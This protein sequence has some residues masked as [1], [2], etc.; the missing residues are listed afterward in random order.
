M[1]SNFQVFCLILACTVTAFPQ[2]Q[3]ALAPQSDVRRFADHL[4]DQHDYGRARIE[5]Q[6]SLLTDAHN[7]SA[8]FNIGLCLIRETNYPAA[9][10]CFETLAAHTPDS[11]LRA[12]CRDQTVFCRYRLGHYDDCLARLDKTFKAH[13]RYRAL[14]ALCLLEKGS[15]GPFRNMILHEQTKPLLPDEMRLCR[16]LVA[17]ADTMAALKRKSPG[18]AAAVSLV[19]G[20][21][22]V[23]AGHWTN[24]VFSFLTITTAYA[25]TWRLAEQNE[26]YL[27]VLPA[28]IGVVFHA[29][30]IFG[31]AVAARNHYQQ[32]Y[33]DVVDRMQAQV[34]NEHWFTQL[35]WERSRF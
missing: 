21:G 2:D 5:Y 3:P 35:G 19:P 30:S 15:A 10:T 22:S 31:S 1:T 33:T 9:I 12:L 27:A 26:P 29:G 25:I 8:A 24:G 6:R 17:A 28:G 14:A 13:F 11:S 4:F 20:L 32:G 18:L 16:V 7:D 23:Y 34:H